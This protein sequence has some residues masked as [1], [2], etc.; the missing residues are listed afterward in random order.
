MGTA[1]TVPETRSMT[2]EELDADDAWATLRRYGGW[3]LV[4]DSIVRFRYGDGF[5]HSR[6]LAFQICLS[7]IPGV[8]AV[9]GLS[10]VLHQERLGRVL[11]LTIHRFAPVSGAQVVRDA[12]EVSR[13]HADDGGAIALWFGLLTAVVGLTTAM[14]QV[15]R[16][17]NRIYGVERDSP[18]RHKYLKAMVM[19]VTAGSFMTL[20]FIILVGGAGLGRAF[21]EVYHWSGTALT[22][23]TLLRWPAGFLLAVLS[24]SVLFRAAPRRRQP[25]H[26]WLAGGAIVALALWTVFSWG[27]SLYVE[28]SGSFGQTYGPL[29]AVM[30]LMLWSLLSSV[31]LFL[32]LSFAAQ[33]EACRGGVGRPATPDPGP[34]GDPAGPHARGVEMS[35]VRQAAEVG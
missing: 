33:L 19:A 35:E 16:G 4:R 31:A 7:V 32:G 25:G 3:H 2:G 12:L 22:A 11:E 13:R 29:T 18:F 14:A 6:A 28:R 9:V 20:G 1:N 26:T 15:E 24:A 30:A 27:L 5:S 8:I 21:A 17:A 10:S 23:W 34:A